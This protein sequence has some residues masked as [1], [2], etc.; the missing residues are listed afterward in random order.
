VFQDHYWAE[1]D[2]THYD[3]LFGES[4]KVDTSSWLPFIRKSKVKISDKTEEVEFFGKKGSKESEQFKVKETDE[5]EVEKF[6]K[7]VGRPEI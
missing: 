2:G 6:W 3:V 1:C 4:G 5:N 7:L